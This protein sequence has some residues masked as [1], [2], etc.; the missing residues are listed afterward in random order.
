MT[1]VEIKYQE[2]KEVTHTIESL[3][4]GQFFFADHPQGYSR[5]YVKAYKQ[6]VWLDDAN[7]TWE[8]DT[9]SITKNFTNI[10]PMAKVTITCE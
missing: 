7:H 2:P 4:I 1:K 6:I 10:L 5:L 8:T 3:P 9:P